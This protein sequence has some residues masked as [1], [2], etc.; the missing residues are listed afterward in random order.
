M[1]GLGLPSDFVR[2]GLLLLRSGYVRELAVASYPH[3]QCDGAHDAEVRCRRPGVAKCP[4]RDRAELLGHGAA[5]A[6]EGSTPQRAHSAHKLLIECRGSGL[7]RLKD[8]ADPTGFEPVTSAFGEQY[9]TFLLFLS[10]I[11]VPESQPKFYSL[12]IE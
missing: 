11:A 2:K 8:L 5:P 4:N 9:Q 12:V 1:P 7:K 3:I 6:N 10:G